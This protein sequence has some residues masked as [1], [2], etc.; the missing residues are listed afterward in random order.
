[1][2]GTVWKD[3]HPLGEEPSTP[4]H[5]SPNTSSRSKP[6]LEICF[7]L[8]SPSPWGA[9]RTFARGGEER[10]RSFDPRES[11]ESLEVSES[12]E[13]SESL[14]VS[15]SLLLSVLLS[16]PLCDAIAALSG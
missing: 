8:S 7:F 12:L 16:V 9:D 5:P 3:I 11:L 13:A 4:P 1:M 10:L 15:E 14:E 6:R 2:D